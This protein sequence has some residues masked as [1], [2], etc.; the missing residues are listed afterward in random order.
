MQIEHP[1]ESFLIYE[2]KSVDTP[3]DE[4]AGAKIPH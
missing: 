2:M 3:A 1:D 4:S